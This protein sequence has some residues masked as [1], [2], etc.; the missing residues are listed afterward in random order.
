MGTAAKRG[1]FMGFHAAHRLVTHGNGIQHQGIHGAKH[2]NVGKHV[3]YALPH[4]PPSTVL[5][6]PGYLLI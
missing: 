1:V 3:N 4:R 6:P 2:H 5:L